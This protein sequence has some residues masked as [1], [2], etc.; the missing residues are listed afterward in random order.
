MAMRIAVLVCV[1]T[2]SN[3]FAEPIAVHQVCVGNVSEGTVAKA[4]KWLADHQQPDGSWASRPEQAKPNAQAAP[5]S[6]THSTGIVLLSLLGAGTTHLEGPYQKEVRHGLDY[7]KTQMAERDDL[8]DLRGG[9]W[10]HGGARRGSPG[11]G[12]S[13]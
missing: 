13:V 10:R 11:A 5:I 8:G 7:L 9:Q 3:L 12:R 4:L 2:M 6:P 1:A